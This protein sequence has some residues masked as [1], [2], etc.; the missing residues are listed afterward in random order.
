MG[1]FAICGAFM[2]LNLDVE[3]TQNV[4]NLNYALYDV[5]CVADLP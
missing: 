2:T 5:Y 1:E 4:R 3:D